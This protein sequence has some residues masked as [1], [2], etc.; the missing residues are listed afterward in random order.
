MGIWR[1]IP[2]RFE[3]GLRVTDS[4]TLEI[5]RM[6]LQGQLNPELVLMVE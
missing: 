1:G 2:A 5:V 4:Q 3:N 6:V